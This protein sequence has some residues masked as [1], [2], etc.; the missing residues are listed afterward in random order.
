LF[1]VL[2]G[3]GG[4]GLQPSVQAVLVDLF[5]GKQRGMAMAFYT[6]AMLCAPV[7]GPTLGGWITDN[8]SWRWIFYINVPVGI[9]CV[10][11][12]QVLLYDPPDLIARRLAQR[13]KPLQ[14]DYVGLAF[15]S[16]GLACI[17]VMLDKGQEDDWFGSNFILTLAV[18]G[19]VSLVFAIAW[20]LNHPRPMLNLRLLAERNF[21][22]CCGIA[23]SLYACIYACNVLLPELMQTLMGYSPT[24][25]GLILSPAG[26]FTM[27]EVPIIGYLLTRGVDPR[28]L[29]ALGLSIVA[30]STLWMSGLNLTAAPS[31]ILWPRVYQS[32]GSGMMF[33]PLST[34]AFKFLPREES[35][36]ASALYALVRN[37]GS[38]LGVALVTTLLARANQTHQAYLVAHITPYSASARQMMQHLSHLA[39]GSDPVY[40]HKFGLMMAYNLVSQQASILSYLD[41]FR[42]FGFLI[43]LIVPLVLLLK[44]SAVDKNAPAEAVH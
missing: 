15:I 5:P 36:N 10:L 41:Q 43:L 35:G 26:L 19:G 14:V 25:A 1:R 34:I 40:A 30:A 42:S 23:M 24:M 16:L 28:L 20:E 31:S 21:A 38:S 4:G 44:K 9:A 33:V 2:Q 29:I 12:S 7:L 3:I 27:V 13:G 11:A 6:I 8:Y 17:E 39:G 32:M 37:E 18:V 22:V